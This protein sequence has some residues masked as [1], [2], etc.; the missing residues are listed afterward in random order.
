MCHNFDFAA[1][2]PELVSIRHANKHDGGVRKEAEVEDL[3]E[4]GIAIDVRRI[5]A[6][7]CDRARRLAVAQRVVQVRYLHVYWVN[8]TIRSLVAV[9]SRRIQCV[10]K[11]KAAR[12]Y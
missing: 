1:I 5:V 12:E 3:V 11:Q 7:Q 2:L 6:K 8:N 10:Y 9:R 4:F